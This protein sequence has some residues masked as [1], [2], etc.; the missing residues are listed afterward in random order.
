MVRVARSLAAA[1]AACFCLAAAAS[2]KTPEVLAEDDACLREGPSCAVNA[3]QTHASARD[4]ALQLALAELD[5]KGFVAAIAR[6]LRTGPDKLSPVLL[7]VHAQL[8]GL[9]RRA[10]EVGSDSSGDTSA[11]AQLRPASDPIWKNV[12]S[13]GNFLAT[14]QLPPDSDP[15]WKNLTDV[16][17]QAIGLVDPDA[18]EWQGYCRDGQYEKFANKSCHD[19]VGSFVKEES[20]RAGD[21]Y[22]CGA[23][24]NIDWSSWPFNGK[25][26]NDLCHAEVGSAYTPTG[27]CGRLTDKE[28]LLNL[29]TT[30]T[31]WTTETQLVNVASADCILGIL[32]CDIYYCKKC[33]CDDD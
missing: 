25:P 8:V 27:I 5:P 23:R 22:F 15:I 7:E 13:I 29:I 26:L 20:G 21:S 4:R 3:L 17:K 33:R 10:A 1:A 6:R 28:L 2:A 31:S 18:F 16:M 30:Y 32:D 9:F 11:A 14:L 24:R 12:T 19:P